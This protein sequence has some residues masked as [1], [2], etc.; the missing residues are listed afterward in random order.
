MNKTLNCYIEY[1]DELR[2]CQISY[3]ANGPYVYLSGN[4][5]SLEDSDETGWNAVFDLIGDCYYDTM[6]DWCWQ[7]AEKISKYFGIKREEE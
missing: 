6:Q 4:R 3:D 5:F 7:N 2:K 1:N